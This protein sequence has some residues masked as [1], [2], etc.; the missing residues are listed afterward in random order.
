MSKDTHSLFWNHSR[1]LCLV[2]TSAIISTSAC[3]GACSNSTAKF[4]AP[5]L[6]LA[7]MMR[8]ETNVMRSAGIV[9]DK[10]TR[11]M[12]CH[13]CPAHAHV[14]VPMCFECPLPFFLSVLTHVQ[15]VH[16]RFQSSLLYMYILYYFYIFCI[17]ANT[18]WI[19]YLGENLFFPKYIYSDYNFKISE[20]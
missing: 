7:P 9:S 4:L 5:S 14:C 12:R 10:H 16:H 6:N 18:D 13:A 15:N 1:P 11:P 3:L 8:V 17:F 2:I 19:K 20:W